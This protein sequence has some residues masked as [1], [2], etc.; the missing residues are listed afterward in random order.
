MRKLIFDHVSVEVTRRCNLKCRHC[1]R[2][3]AQEVDIDLHSIE[4]L[5]EQ[6]A[7]IYNLSF[8]GGEPT[9]NV[10]AMAYTL[11]ALRQR[12]IPLCSVTVTTNGTLKSQG[13]VETLRGFSQYIAPWRE[14]DDD[15]RLLISKD[16]YHKGADPDGALVFYQQEL[17]GTVSVEL[18][19]VGEKPMAIGRGR[20][21]EG[22]KTPPIAGSTPHK[23][24]T[25]EEGKPCG[26]RVW[27]EWPAPRGTEK[28]VCCRLAL[29]A[30]GDLTPC[31]STDG[32]YAVDDRRRDLVICNLSPDAKAEGRDID[33]GIERY[34]KRFPSCHD[35]E[36]QETIRQAAEYARRPMQVIADIRW[37]YQL[38]QSD[39]GAKAALLSQTPDLEEQFEMLLGLFD[40]AECISEE[41]L[42]KAMR[43]EILKSSG[44]KYVVFE[45]G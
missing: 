18:V 5:L 28:L 19:M 43:N 40:I 10:P 36:E 9:L 11:E 16:R 14:P 45:D 34:N 7:K 8:T 38:M 25:M 37:A 35:A 4:A 39:P 24:E 26:C 15:V 29:S 22:A 13:L 41:Y 6:T 31:M 32:E 44:G 23:I 2:G 3:D 27:R 30:H 12:E 1:L 17:A 33:S 20:T 21:L 42:A